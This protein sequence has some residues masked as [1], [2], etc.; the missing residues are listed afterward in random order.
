MILI[1]N[2]HGENTAG[3]R[4][5][6][7]IFREYL[8]AREIAQEI[9]RELRLKG[10]DCERIVKGSMDTPL[11]ERVRIVN[12]YCNKLKPKNVA[13][14]SI[15]VNAAGNGEQWMNA[16]GWSAY[17]CKGKTKSD[18]LATLLY[19]EAEKHFTNLRMDFQDGDPDWEE[20][21]CLLKNTRCPAVITEN[22]FMD[23]KKDVSYLLSKE[24][25]DTI[26]KVHVD[27]IVRYV[28]NYINV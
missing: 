24:G 23:N 13:L 15:H 17:T 2:G 22:F 28:D 25:R 27:A 8:Y 20:D 26:I 21:F 14:V 3:K 6:D 16:R 4:S 18:K 9:E 7:G 10:Y 11:K 19:E 5:P 1:D 12:E